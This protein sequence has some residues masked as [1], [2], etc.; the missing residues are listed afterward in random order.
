MAKQCH[1]WNKFELAV[2]VEDYESYAYLEK[3]TCILF[4]VSNLRT[5]K[6]C[7]KF[8]VPYLYQFK[9]TSDGRCK[10]FLIQ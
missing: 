3:I 7:S 10:M 8:I 5:K 9:K 4:T 6:E 2:G 1:L